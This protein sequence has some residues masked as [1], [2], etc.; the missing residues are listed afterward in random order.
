MYVILNLL[1]ILNYILFY[2]LPFNFI[3]DTRICDIVCRRRII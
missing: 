1:L 2:L 3:F